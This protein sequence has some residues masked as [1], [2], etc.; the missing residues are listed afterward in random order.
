MGLYSARAAG[1]RRSAGGEGPYLTKKDSH[2]GDTT[3]V[4]HGITRR[5]R[6]VLLTDDVSRRTA[7]AGKHNYKANAERE[8]DA[9]V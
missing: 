5:K 8:C 6:F 7:P 3:R 9:A 2:L 1:V 4:L